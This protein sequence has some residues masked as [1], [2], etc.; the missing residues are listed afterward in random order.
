[1]SQRKLFLLIGAGLLAYRLM[2][3]S[4]PAMVAQ[5]PTTPRDPRDLDPSLPFI[6]VEPGAALA[7][8]ADNP[9]QNLE[10]LALGWTGWGSSGTTPC[11]S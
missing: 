10:T 7:F 11:E 5:Q 6:E 3:A 1:M 8:A 9:I 2:N 4:R